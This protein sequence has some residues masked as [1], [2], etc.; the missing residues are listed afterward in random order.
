VRG[1]TILVLYS[2]NLTTFKRGTKRLKKTHS[3]LWGPRRGKERKKVVDSFSGR[4]EKKKG[5]ISMILYNPSPK[6][7]GTGTGGTGEALEERL[8]MP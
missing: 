8:K 7:G 1:K 3:D 2:M 5:E 6:A 4:R